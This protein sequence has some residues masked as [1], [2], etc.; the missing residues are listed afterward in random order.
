M[1]GIQY[2]EKVIEGINLNTNLGSA[3]TG[4][5]DDESIYRYTALFKEMT[6]IKYTNRGLGGYWLEFNCGC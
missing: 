5:T 1:E 3:D 6:P 4:C 2:L